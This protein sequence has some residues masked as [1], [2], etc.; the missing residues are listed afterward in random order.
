MDGLAFLSEAANIID[1]RDNNNERD[2]NDPSIS[3]TRKRKVKEVQLS[4]LRNKITKMPSV[5]RSESIG[6]AISRSE[7]VNISLKTNRYV[8]WCYVLL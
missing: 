3:P 8:D 2:G 1:V 7:S 5:M 4:P 6:K